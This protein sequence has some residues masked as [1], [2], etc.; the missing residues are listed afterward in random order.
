[1][2]TVDLT[3]LKEEE[4]AKIKSIFAGVY[5]SKLNI[6]TTCAELGIPISLGKQWYAEPE[7]KRAIQKKMD[8]RAKK[9]DITADYV[10]Q[11][12]KEIAM[13]CRIS[14][15]HKDALKALELLG[16][17]LKLFTDK[18]EHTGTAVSFNLQLGVETLSSE[19]PAFSQSLIDENV[20][21]E[22]TL[23]PWV[24]DEKYRYVPPEPEPEP[25]PE[26]IVEPT[27]HFELPEELKTLSV[28]EAEIAVEMEKKHEPIDDGWV[29]P[30][31]NFKKMKKKVERGN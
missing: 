20:I 13:E 22:P 11:E 10:L 31:E 28:E 5:I 23:K 30:F 3:E 26:P 2:E 29:S 12:I 24:E 17:H 7:M 21:D 16:K 25:T 15:E 8:K 14:K 6:T 27:H 9:V 18:V 19:Q 1:M 4:V